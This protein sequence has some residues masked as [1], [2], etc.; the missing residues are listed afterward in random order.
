M[1]RRIDYQTIAMDLIVK[2]PKFDLELL[3]EKLQVQNVERH[4]FNKL[5]ATLNA[6]GYKIHEITKGIYEVI[7]LTR[8]EKRRLW[9]E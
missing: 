8:E 4:Y 2:V 9:E 5:N 6:N 7:E 1:P 3:K